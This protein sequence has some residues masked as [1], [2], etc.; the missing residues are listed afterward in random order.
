VPF[1]PMLFVDD[2]EASS[3]FYQRLLNAKSGH[4]GNEYEMIVD[5]DKTLLLQLHHADGE[6]HGDILPA[7]V[8]RG[9]GVLLYF[10]VADVREAYTRAQS[11]G[12]RIEGE[13]AYIDKAFHT[14][15]VVRD[16]DGYSIALFQRGRH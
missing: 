1:D 11:M 8:R 9:A 3:R 13:P 2:V 7:G 5:A 6:E 15:F 10:K 16:P 12:A 14:E 4:G